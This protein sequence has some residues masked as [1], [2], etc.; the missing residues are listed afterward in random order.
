MKI[1]RAVFGCIC[2]ILLIEMGV[3]LGAQEL[4][5]AQ[6]KDQD[7][8]FVTPPE[9][10]NVTTMSAIT[11]HRIMPIMLGGDRILEVDDTDSK[12]MVRVD[13]DGKV[14]YGEGYKPDDGARAFWETMAKYY[15]VVSNCPDAKVGFQGGVS[16]TASGGG[17]GV[18]VVANGGGPG[19]K[20]TGLEGTTKDKYDDS[21]FTPEAQCRSG[22]TKTAWKNP[23]YPYYIQ[24]VRLKPAK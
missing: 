17:T 1:G 4:H 19:S 14:S 13:L 15:P 6:N 10:N 24:C 20:T 9:G 22:F 23:G 11:I 16:G 18:S 3:W 7:K 2:S 12:V 5:Q 8:L 21:Y